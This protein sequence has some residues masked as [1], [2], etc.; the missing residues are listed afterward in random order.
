[1]ARRVRIVHQLSLLLATAVLLAVLALSA[2]VAWNLRSGFSGYLQARD[3]TEVDRLARQV[4]LRYADEPQL[5]SL[6]SDRSAMRELIDGLLPAYVHEQ[7]AADPDPPTVTDRPGPPLHMLQRARI[8]DTEGAHLAGPPM[9]T[10]I[11]RLRSAVNI[12]GATVAYAEL[13]RPPRLE[14]IDVRF[15]QRQYIGLAVVAALTLLAACASAWV[16]ARRWSRPL[17]DIQSAAQRIAQGEFDV[18]LP[19]SRTLEIGALTQAIGRMAQSLQTLE[20]ARRRW[21]AQISHE[22][23][24]PL[25]VLRGELEA[26]NEGVRTPAPHVIAG[27]NEQALHLAR[28]VNDLHMLAIADL[29]GMPCNFDWGDAG[30]WLQRHAQ[31]YEP[32]ARQAS[33][34]LQIE[35][36]P[37]T[38]TAPAYWDFDRIAQVIGVLLDNSLRYTQ[39]PGRV[40]VRGVADA[41]AKRW[42]IDVSDSAPAVPAGDLDLLFDPLFRSTHASHPGTGQGSGLGLAIAKSIVVAHGGSISASLSALGGLTVSIDLPWEAR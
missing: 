17:A 2:A 30:P 11:E 18:A 31:R 1:M 41:Q 4:S 15:L 9:P 27:L 16:A 42:R 13:P 28:L 29:G 24:T 14:A 7:R 3:Q 5:Q 25:A 37:A 23:R 19:S 6:R 26:M 21:L 39:T 8:V 38:Q 32:L 33:L 12:G 34:D 10:H 36:T 35:V 40:Q 20:S 22:L